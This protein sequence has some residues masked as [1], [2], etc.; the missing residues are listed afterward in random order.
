MLWSLCALLNHWRNAAVDKQ[1]GAGCRR[2][3][4]R[5]QKGDSSRDFTRQHLATERNEA[6]DLGA[7][8]INALRRIINF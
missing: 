3:L 5:D 6:G 7:R 8:F 4:V 1:F 2:R